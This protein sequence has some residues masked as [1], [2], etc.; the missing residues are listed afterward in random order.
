LP[1]FEVVVEQNLIRQLVEEHTDVA[2]DEAH[3]IA[4][5]LGESTQPECP[6][7]LSLSQ[8]RDMITQL[9]LFTKV[10]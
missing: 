10:H 8:A 6:A 3:D 7:V 4:V 2:D 1:E 9:I 5:E